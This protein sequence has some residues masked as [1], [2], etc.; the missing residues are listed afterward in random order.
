MQRTVPPA[1][2]LYLSTS[3]FLGLS[4]KLNAADSA[5]LQNPVASRQ[6]QPKDEAKLKAATS[7]DEIAFPAELL[8]VP[9][10]KVKLG[11]DVKDFVD[12]LAPLNRTKKLQITDLQRCMAELGQIEV[13]VEPFFLNKHPVTM[14][15]Y[16][17]FIEE[18]GH[19]FP[20]DWWRYGR[21]DNYNELLKTIN[22]EVKEPGNKVLFYW[23]VHWKELPWKIP[24]HK[25]H[26]S[27]KPTKEN[28]PVTW[29]SWDDAV[30]FAAWAGMRLPTE[31]EWVFA[32]TGNK[33]K[34]FL[35]GDELDGLQIKRGAR[36]DKHWPVGKWGQD[37]I[38]PFGHEDMVLHVYEWTGDDGYFPLVPEKEFEK[39]RKKL[40][41][42]KLFKNKD[43]SAVKSIMGYHPKWSGNIHTAK[44]G[45]YASQRPSELR[46][47]TRVPQE[48]FQVRA[49]LGFR[50]AKSHVPA[51]DIVLSRIQLDYDTTVFSG[52]REPN[53]R[54]QVG[55]ERYELMD[56][57]RLITGYHAVSLVPTSY[58]GEDKKVSEAKYNE[59]ATS[60]PQPI[61]TLMT[62]EKLSQPQVDP[63]IYTVYF[64]HLG[65]PKELSDALASGNRELVAEEKAR[66]AAEK[67]AAKG[68]KPKKKSKKKKKD[69]GEQETKKTNWRAVTKKYGITE[70]EVLAGEVNFVR[71]KPGDL[72][73]PTDRH[74][75]VIRSN[76]GQFT[77]AWDGEKGAIG[78]KYADGNASVMIEALDQGERAVFQFGVP[79]FENSKGK[80]YQF[81]VP[82]VLPAESAGNGSWR[83]K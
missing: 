26:P 70:A 54:D 53:L 58:A 20:F 66:L 56:N 81:I 74:Q 62:T 10:G 75:F 28:Y 23:K 68:R 55:M 42:D 19:R 12:A 18:T 45:Y 83:T 38:G 69:E 65:M 43:N 59:R 60:S 34:Q 5:K 8:P 3:F 64:R 37:A 14:E 31:A 72:K 79:Q 36:N 33:P 15:Q 82:L 35:W 78:S 57:N 71:L 40:L 67:A 11:T 47:Q 51:R 9:G 25:E 1:A 17:I 61:A 4:P 2:I 41:K 46:I 16:R 63:G 50:V 30:A 52:N 24:V 77:F 29:V 80:V 27:P 49:G 13:E 48:S 73:V 44:G 22:E 7:K 76:E 39:Q 32:A 21:E 6:A